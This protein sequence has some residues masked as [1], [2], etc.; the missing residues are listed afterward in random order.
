MRGAAARAEGACSGKLR[1]RLLMRS[2]SE[3]LSSEILETCK[4]TAHVSIWMI[5]VDRTS[6][7]RSERGNGLDSSLTD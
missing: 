4:R 3:L 7:R 1:F 2:D 5:T 6:E